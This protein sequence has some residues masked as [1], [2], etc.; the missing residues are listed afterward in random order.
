MVVNREVVAG[1]VVEGDRA[2]LAAR[3]AGGRGGVESR[4]AAHVVAVDGD[5]SAAAVALPGAR[6]SV[7][8]Q[9][10]IPGQGTRRG[11]IDLGDGGFPGAGGSIW[12]TA[13]S[14]AREPA[15]T[16]IDPPAPP[17]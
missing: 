12:V 14:P 1:A 16:Q 7:R 8:G 6:T 4:K 3:V 2:A 10:A 9:E 5:A 13:G 15:V 17:S 11:G